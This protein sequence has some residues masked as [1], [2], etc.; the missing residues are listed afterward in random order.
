[1]ATLSS[2]G[3]RL[4]TQLDLA[5]QVTNLNTKKFCKDTLKLLNK[6]LNFIPTQ[7][8]VNKDTINKQFQDFLE[9][10]SKIRK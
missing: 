2:Y 4:K 3:K 6:N 5:G 7:K 10:V 9:L 1:M 8:T